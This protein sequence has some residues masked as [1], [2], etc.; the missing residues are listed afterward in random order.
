MPRWVQIQ[1]NFKIQL[2]LFAVVVVEDFFKGG[3]ISGNLFVL[4]DPIDH[5]VHHPATS[6]KSEKYPR[7]VVIRNV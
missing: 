3:A 6:D 5:F 4:K 1:V 7:F 2:K